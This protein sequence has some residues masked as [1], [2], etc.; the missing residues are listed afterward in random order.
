VSMVIV[1]ASMVTSQEAVPVPPLSLPLLA[2]PRGSKLLRGQV[3]ARRAPVGG[4]GIGAV[5]RSGPE[6]A[7][8]VYISTCF[9]GCTVFEYDQD[10]R[11]QELEEI[12]S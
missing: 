2:I 11:G 7:G 1:M 3:K 4:A 9:L 6:A 5:P 10:V 8:V 12:G